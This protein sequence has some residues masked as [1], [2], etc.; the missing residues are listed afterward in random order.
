MKT[1]PHQALRAETRSRARDDTRRVHKSTEKVQRWEKKWVPVKDTSML[2]YKWVPVAEDEHAQPKKS[3]FVRAQANVLAPTGGSIITMSSCPPEL[4]TVDST[5]IEG[6][7]SDR[8]PKMEASSEISNNTDVKVWNR[9]NKCTN[10]NLTEVSLALRFGL[11]S[12]PSQ[13]E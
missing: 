8:M 3:G 5:P 10:G 6:A 11:P 9:L 1:I 7:P 2:I 13:D 4:R 12:F